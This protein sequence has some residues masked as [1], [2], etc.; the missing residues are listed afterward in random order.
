MKRVRFFINTLS[1]L[2]K[3]AFI[4]KNTSDRGGN[5]Y[6]CLP[7]VKAF[8]CFLV[9]WKPCC[10]KYSSLLR[11][12]F[13]K[14]LTS[15]LLFLISILRVP[16]SRSMSFLLF[17]S[18]IC[19]YGKSTCRPSLSLRVTA[20]RMNVMP[21]I[22]LFLKMKL[23]LVVY[24][25]IRVARAGI[26]SQL[27]CSFRQSIWKRESMRR[28][29]LLNWD[30]IKASV[31]SVSISYDKCLCLIFTTSSSFISYCYY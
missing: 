20:F 13:S 26:S 30:W 21:L 12:L 19:A 2:N 5:S 23:L 27:R 17:M 22:I 16:I 1:F 31:S 11:K 24:T 15:F 25:F 29:S 9:T 8:C 28:S 10:L 14:C 7:V 6:Y 4:S 3:G 18:D